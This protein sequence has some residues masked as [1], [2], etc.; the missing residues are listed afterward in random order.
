MEE[1][2][3]SRS[4]TLTA[5]L[6]PVDRR[7]LAREAALYRERALERFLA[8]IERRAFRIAEMALRDR[9]EAE[10]AVQ[11]A[12]IRLVRSYGSRPQDEWRP[13][14]YRILKN[15]ITDL[16]RKR[17]VRSVIQT[18][19]SGGGADEAPDP[20][21]SAVDPSGSPEQELEGRELLARIEEVLAGLSGRQ[22]EAVMLRNSKGRRLRDGVAMG[23]SKASEALLPRGAGAA[24]GTGGMEL[25]NDER[26]RELERRSRAAFDES[27]ESIDAA[28]RSRL[29]RAR[30]EALR[31]LG[32]RRLNWRSAWVPAGVAAAAALASALLFVATMP[33]ARPPPR[34]AALEDLAIVAG[35]EHLR[36][37]RGPR[38]FMPGAGEGRRGR[39]IYAS[40]R[41]HA[42]ARLRCRQRVGTTGTPPD[43]R[44]ESWRTADED[45]CRRLHGIGEWRTGI[46]AAEKRPEGCDR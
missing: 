22:R 42:C 39:L 23:C 8:N 2:P 35:R 29:A 26:I 14:F 16:Q 5:P 1:E 38:S 32:V 10:D 17:K 7:G 41:T 28:T 4:A 30:A 34:A 21:E 33:R 46:E 12:M 43:R 31:E 40:H 36:F 15:R 24:I 20:V 44:P 6:S 9:A 37:R 19:W 18:W 45:E 3:L 13:L 11:D 27:V 25:M